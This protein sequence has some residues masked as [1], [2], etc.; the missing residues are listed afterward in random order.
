MPFDYELFY[1]FIKLNLNK[2]VIGVLEPD[3]LKLLNEDVEYSDFINNF[4]D[5]KKELKQ[6]CKCSNKDN[7]LYRRRNENGNFINCYKLTNYSIRIFDENNY[8]L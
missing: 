5:F 6:I 3:L 7:R 2:F 8:Y 1:W 4:K